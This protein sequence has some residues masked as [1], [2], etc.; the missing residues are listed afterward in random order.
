MSQQL[1]A[2]RERQ[3]PWLRWRSATRLGK[4][5]V[6][7]FVVWMLLWALEYLPGALGEVFSVARFFALLV[8]F[9]SGAV[10]LVRWF[11]RSLLWRLRNRLVVTY[12]L[13]GLAPIVLLTTLFGLISYLL[14]GQFAIFAAGDELNRHLNVMGSENREIVVHLTHLPESVWASGN[15]EVPEA[16]PEQGM[17]RPGRTV[18]IFH[19][20]KPVR[21][22]TGRVEQNA[23]LKSAPAWVVNSYTGIVND[24]GKLYVRSV[25]AREIA[26]H[27]T[28]VVTS[29]P[30]SSAILADVAEGLGRVTI[31]NAVAEGTTNTDGSSKGNFNMNFSNGHASHV[32]LLNDGREL[33]ESQIRKLSMSGGTLPEK[34]SWTD[35]NVSFLTPLAMRD[36]DTG[37]PLSTTMSVSSRP[38]LLY[39]R[40]F[41]SSVTFGGIIR[42]ALITVGITFALI[43]ALALF[44]AMRLNRVITRS[45][46][47]L[48]Q[49]TRRVD[50][51]DLEHQIPVR[52][53]D[54][55]GAL[56]AS[57]N[58]MTTSLRRLL[59][60]QKEKERL[61]NELAIAQEVQA[62]LFPATG[63]HLA[64]LEV[65]GI[66]RPARTVSGDYY[67]FLMFGDTS[68]GLALG[69]ISGKGISAALLMATL[70]SAVRAYR[71]AAEEIVAVE[72]RI[73]LRNGMA[74]HLRDDDWVKM[75]EC[76]GKLLELLNRHLY[77]STQPEK[78]ATLWLGSY[79]GAKSRLVYSNGGQLPPL[80][81]CRTGEVKRLD[82]GGTVVGLIDG[83]SYDEGAVDLQAGDIVIAYSDGVTEP[84]NDFGDFGEDRLLEVVR[85]YRNSPLEVISGQV[86][87]ALTDWIGAAEQPDD[88]T[89]VL[90]RQA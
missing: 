17:G 60:E 21:M 39:H 79:D 81:L 14:A 19:D 87:A 9:V 20:G 36:W 84:E 43:E 71:F 67:D 63:M 24:G 66:C 34:R 32:K 62:N 12:L 38:S 1:S 88:I 76:P 26:G 7:T 10:W 58:S 75:F 78:Y 73:R 35:V 49:G 11:R 74:T 2:T 50:E 80:V 51:G 70:H 13:V 5:V 48:Y 6:I 57:F 23:D 47:E 44:A 33:D 28:Q 86:M 90:A 65:H 59:S 4:F 56:N 31:L 18:N 29:E 3:N 41:S 61:Q 8:L 89:L 46:A 22:A 40:L 45:V 16:E 27:K 42:A 25:T 72:D 54:Q 15:P 69:D 37:G 68:L 82:K 55:L 30:M 53:L 77:R 64:G 52:Q 83:A 85:Q